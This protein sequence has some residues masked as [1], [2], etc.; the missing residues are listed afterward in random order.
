VHRSVALVACALALLAA[1]CGDDKPP[2]PPRAAVH[3]TLTE[4]GDG[5]SGA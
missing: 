3:V 2:A 1:G 4:P 5:A